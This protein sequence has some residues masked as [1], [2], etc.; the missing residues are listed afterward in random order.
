MYIDFSKYQ[1]PIKELI[2]DHDD[3]DYISYREIII[4][5]SNDTKIKFIAV[6]DCCS[7]SF[8]E[9]YENYD[10]QNLIGKIITDVKEIELPDDYEY[11]EESNNGYCIIPHLYEIQFKK[12][13]ETFKFILVN[14]SN[15]YYDG[16]LETELI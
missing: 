11:K 8:I 15:G 9:Q 16:W 7:S 1:L 10:F 6:G 14:F 12:T 4:I 5:L 3:S 13:K 2:F